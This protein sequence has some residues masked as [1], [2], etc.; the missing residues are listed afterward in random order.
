MDRL[1]YF[2][3]GGRHNMYQYISDKAVKTKTEK[4]HPDIIQR[5]YPFLKPDTL[6]KGTVLYH[7]TSGRSAADIRKKIQFSYGRGTQLGSGFYTTRD[8]ETAQGY[9]KGELPEIITIEALQDMEGQCADTLDNGTA[10]SPGDLAELMKREDAESLTVDR[11]S[12]FVNALPREIREA[13]WKGITEDEI[14]NRDN[15]FIK[16]D[17]ARDPN[18]PRFT[19]WLNQYKFTQNAEGKIGVKEEGSDSCCLII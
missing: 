12:E 19:T 8:I 14:L 9:L 13:T 2:E 10:I 16:T 1:Y 18:D 4:K 17:E 7:G 5:R 15:D 3:K 6:D 11:A